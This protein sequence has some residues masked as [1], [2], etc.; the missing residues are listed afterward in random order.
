MTGPEPATI[1]INE[2]VF[3]VRPGISA[4]EAAAQLDPGLPDALR[5][6]TAYLTDGRG[7]AISPDQP[8]AAGTILRVIRRAAEPPSR[9]DVQSAEPPS[10]RDAEPSR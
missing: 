2:Q 4:A 7:I 10:R 9:R 3:R 1:F 6:G 5:D 8:V